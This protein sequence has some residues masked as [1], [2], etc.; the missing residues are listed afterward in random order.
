MG[1]YKRMALRIYYKLNKLLRIMRFSQ[2]MANMILQQENVIVVYFTR[3]VGRII[4]HKK[5]CQ[6]DGDLVKLLNMI[7]IMNFQKMFTFK[8][9]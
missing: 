5:Q 8:N 1:M 9:Q 6:K 7:Q 4:Y 2:E 3:I